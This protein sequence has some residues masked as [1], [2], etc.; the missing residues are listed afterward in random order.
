MKGSE[1]RSGGK[2]AP[3]RCRLD[4]EQLKALASPSRALGSQ[5]PLRL[6]AGFSAPLLALWPTWLLVRVRF[7]AGG[8]VS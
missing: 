3:Q 5:A 6:D 1:L 8:A 2:R 7:G 4:L